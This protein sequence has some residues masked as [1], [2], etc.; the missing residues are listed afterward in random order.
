MIHLQGMTWDHRRAT[1][2]LAT[3]DVAFGKERPD[4]AV[5]W[6]SRPL[7]GFEFDPIE[8][9]AQENDFVIFD[10]PFC[11]RIAATGCFLSMTQLLEQVG[12]EGAFVGPSMASYHYGDG[13]W[14]IPVD[15]AC[16][17]AV[18]RRD[19]LERLDTGLPIT[20][21]ETCKL[22]ERA[23]RCGL[24]LAIGL[25]GV[26]ALMTLFSLCAA[27]GAPFAG[28]DG[29][30]D[31]TAAPEALSQMRRLL[32]LCNAPVLEWN[33][34]AVHEAL[35]AQ[36]DLV[37][38]PAVYG[39]A[40]YGETDRATRLAFGSFA[41]VASSGSCAGATIG[42]AGLGISARVL[43]DEATHQAALAYA[44]MA[45]SGLCQRQVF[46]AHHGQPAHNDAWRDEAIDAQFNGFYSATR[47][48]LEQT[49]IRPRYDG[50]LAFQGQGGDMVEA[51]LR[52]D[53]SERKLL[54]GLKALALR[55]RGAGT[56]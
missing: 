7:S 37:Y 14:G 40:A 51:H 50:Y 36:D 30:I 52:G 44:R 9:L 5:S 53:L 55:C 48:T 8:R 32:G 12:G 15:A 23:R 1:E 10:H 17:I 56:Q 13:H 46:A 16:Q 20:W 45:A 42:G 43:R 21:E 25:Q 47:Q 54:D 6:R 2:P 34:I 11:G 29:A 39:Y 31:E 19:L 22:G 38:C 26:H 28:D 27:L 49:W 24:S 18:Y 41:G 35:A 33:S 4:V 3:L